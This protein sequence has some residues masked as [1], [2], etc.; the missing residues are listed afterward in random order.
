M[1]TDKGRSSNVTFDLTFIKSCP[2]FDK[3]F[4]VD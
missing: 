4:E 2:Y 1:D 3:L